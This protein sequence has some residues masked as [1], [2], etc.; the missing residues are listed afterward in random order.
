MP[1]VWSFQNSYTYE[2]YCPRASPPVP[3][4]PI[5]TQE[6][7]RPQSTRGT[8]GCFQCSGPSV[9]CRAEGFLYHNTRDGE[10]CGLYS[11]EKGFSNDK[12]LA[13]ENWTNQTMELVEYVQLDDMVILIAWQTISII[14]QTWG[15]FLCNS[16]NADY[17]FVI[18]WRFSTKGEIIYVQLYRPSQ[19]ASTS[20]DGGCWYI[21]RSVPK[22]S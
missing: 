19:A 22:P 2:W 15:L 8:V 20:G 6:A 17:P 11:G 14:D 3:Y 13:K 16:R 10:L 4:P 5:A 21:L 1:I 18:R 9:P 12:F 7:T